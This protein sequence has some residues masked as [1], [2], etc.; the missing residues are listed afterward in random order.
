[1]GLVKNKPGMH[2]VRLI[3]LFFKQYDIMETRF[4]RTDLA[5]KHTTTN[6]FV[7]GVK[8][9]LLFTP[10]VFHPALQRDAPRTSFLFTCRSSK[11]Y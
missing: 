11:L 6:V 1:M 7:T 4:P 10:R 3:S 9:V 8:N 5:K 2:I